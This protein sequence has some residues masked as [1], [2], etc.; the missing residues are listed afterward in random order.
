[1]G[2]TR[3]ARC[4]FDGLADRVG[5][6]DLPLHGLGLERTVD[7]ASLAQRRLRRRARMHNWSRSIVGALGVLGTLGVVLGACSSSGDAP[8][9]GSIDCNIGG[10]GTDPDCVKLGKPRK[11]DC[12]SSAARQSGIAAGCVAEHPDQA[13]D[14]DVCC[15]TTVTGTGGS[16]GTV[17]L[18]D[19]CNKCETCVRDATFSEGFCDPFKTGSTFDTARCKTSGDVK[20]LAKP[21]VSRTTLDAWSCADFDANE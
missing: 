4:R 10:D 3:S 1:M 13:T 5:G 15:P 16:S 14:Y 21:D 9:G 8:G 19:F 20:Q 12:K 17:T 7:G 6:Q 18:A 2:G 11:M